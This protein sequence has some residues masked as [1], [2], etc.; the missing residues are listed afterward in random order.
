MMVP[1]IKRVLIVVL[2]AG[3]IMFA[4]SAWGQGRSGASPTRGREVQEEARY[5]EQLSQQLLQDHLAGMMPLAKVDIEVILKQFVESEDLIKRFNTDEEAPL[6]LIKSLLAHFS[7]DGATAVAEAKAAYDSAPE[8]LEAVEALVAMSCYWGDYQAMK[9]VLSKVQAGKYVLENAALAR[10]TEAASA[11][12]A[13]VSGAATQG[14]DPNSAA[15]SKSERKSEAPE[16]RSRFSRDRSGGSDRGG[17]GQIPGRGPQGMPPGMNMDMDMPMMD[18]P[19]GPGMEMGPG[20]YP[21]GTHRSPGKRPSGAE[22]E[23]VKLKG[24]SYLKLKLNCMPYEQLGEDFPAVQLMNFNHSTFSFR[25]GQG[26]ILCSLLWTSANEDNKPRATARRSGSGVN[27]LTMDM[28]Q[29]MI[30]ANAGKLDIPD[31]TEDLWKNMDQFRWLFED[32]V[33]TGRVVTAAINL[34]ELNSD[35]QKQIATMAV[36]LPCPW[37]VCLQGD[38]INAGQL[39]GLPAAAPIMLLVDTQGKIRYMGPVGGILPQMVIAAQIA[40]A[41]ESVPEV[42]TTMARIETAGGKD[43][44]GQAEEAAEAAAVVEEVKAPEVVEK[45]SEPQAKRKLQVAYVQK[46]LSKQ[47]ALK[48]CDDILEQW[49]DSLEADEAKVLIGTICRGNPSISSKRRAAGQYVGE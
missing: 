14:G 19:M 5:F 17:N 24:K 22:T 16:R 45:V 30:P 10:E 9:E 48:E 36:E 28:G 25:P 41:M 29:E 42:V 43:D 12:N 34:D 18:M 3:M 46:R 1:R 20:G 39:E 23:T 7:R 44:A 32:T 49:P 27:L 6:H 37:P 4:S 13:E 21:G 40:E 2:A 8:S 11:E 26:Q 33:A 38:P 47:S 35:T 15:A 31:P